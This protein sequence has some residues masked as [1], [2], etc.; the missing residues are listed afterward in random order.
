MVDR[1]VE[2]VK[3]GEFKRG[4]GDGAAHFVNIKTHFAQ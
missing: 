2:M 1:K 3:V 4:D